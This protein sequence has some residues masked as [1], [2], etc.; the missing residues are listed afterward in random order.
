[1]TLPKPLF[2]L[3]SYRPSPSNTRRPIYGFCHA[4]YYCLGPSFRITL[5]QCCIPT[6][7]ERSFESDDG[8]CYNWQVIYLKQCHYYN[9]ACYN[10]R[11]SVN[12]QYCK[13]HVYILHSYSEPPITYVV[14]YSDPNCA[15][16]FSQEDLGECCNV[17]QSYIYDPNDPNP[18]CHNWVK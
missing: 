13:N 14:C 1:M 2:I 5:A 12:L 17:G 11:L 18:I 6:D 9:N 15:G 8:D 4:Q 10:T 7:E 16:F 3:L